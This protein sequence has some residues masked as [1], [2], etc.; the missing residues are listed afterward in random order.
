MTEGMFLGGIFNV[1][2]PWL[3][4]TLY[5]WSW[6]IFILIGLVLYAAFYYRG[7]KPF[8]PLHGLYY[9]MRNNS[10]VAWIFDA[11]L[12]GEMLAERDAKCIFD[13]E[14]DFEY[15][16][17]PSWVPVFGFI[18]DWFR[19]KMFYYPTAWLDNIDPAHALF[20]KLM[21][22]N[23]D[24]L[25][26]K[27]MEGNK[28]ERS[29]HVVCAGVPVD[30][31]VDMDNW[32]IKGTPQHKAIVQSAKNWNKVNPDDQIHSYQKY[33][34]YINDPTKGLA[35]PPELKKGVM[36]PWSRI[37]AAFPLDLD[38][39]EWAGKKRQMAKDRE[40]EEEGQLWK[41]IIYVFIGE[42]GIAAL[43]LIIRF[44]LSVMRMR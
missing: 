43:L 33:Q 20:Y 16:L 14:R 38:D 19:A 12:V 3:H 25:I 23:K 21:K 24:V 27:K 10:T 26:A 42:V 34:R 32:T 9:A 7:W 17:D 39:N 41:Y 31:I 13:Y 6:P 2:D 44:A 36:V 29:A 4:L 37:D 30:I 18:I 35:C 40:T 8:E 28:W 22:I 11:Q 15:E 5:M 1:V